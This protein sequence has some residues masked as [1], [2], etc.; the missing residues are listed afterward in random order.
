MQMTILAQIR[1]LLL[2]QLASSLWDPFNRGTPIWVWFIFR[3]TIVVILMYEHG[4]NWHERT[5][6]RWA[7]R[8]AMPERCDSDGVGEKNP[9]MMVLSQNGPAQVSACPRLLLLFFFTRV[10]VFTGHFMNI[11]TLR[12]SN[13]RD[14]KELPLS[15]GDKSNAL[16][17]ALSKHH[18]AFI[19]LENRSK[20][21]NLSSHKTTLPPYT[22]RLCPATSHR[23]G[24]M[25][26][27]TAW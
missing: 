1:L 11:W 12:R 20:W 13:C 18:S 16:T 23:D 9:S 8:L 15:C 24:E 2:G 14:K 7:C 17:T 22:L 10:K 3:Q 19:L 21:S 26:G 4:Q 6:T 5:K 25:T 27:G